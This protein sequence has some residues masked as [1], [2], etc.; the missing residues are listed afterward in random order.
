MDFADS[1]AACPVPKRDWR[2][3]QSKSASA[4]ANTSGAFAPV[5]PTYGAP[6]SHH[7]ASQAVVASIAHQQDVNA[8]LQ[9][10]SL[11]GATATSTAVR[12]DKSFHE[13]PQ[14]EGWPL[15]NRLPI[16]AAAPCGSRSTKRGGDILPIAKSPTL[17]PTLSG[18]LAF[19]ADL[20]QA[21]VASILGKSSNHARHGSI[22]SPATTTHQ[23]TR[24]SSDANTLSGMHLGDVPFS[25]T[26]SATTSNIAESSGR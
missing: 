11:G 6:A 9:A 7:D 4:S 22:D 23:L 19:G 5:P 14:R 1:V 24:R 17:R 16:G 8:V 12:S 3:M 21:D 13:G 15:A 2:D 25:R 20:A 26:I 10:L 18:T